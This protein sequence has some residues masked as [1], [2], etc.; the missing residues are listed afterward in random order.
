MITKSNGDR[1]QFDGSKVRRSILRSGG[2]NAEAD[3]VLRDVQ[4]ALPNGATTRVL[5]ATVHAS[6]CRT[7]RGAACRYTLRDALA[8]LGPAGFHFEKYIAALLA[9]SGYTT[10]LPDEIQGASVLHEIDV[11][12]RQG[13]KTFA[14]ECKFRNAIRD[15][16]H[17]KDTLAGYARYLDLLDG[18]DLGL[19]PKF[20]E[21]WIVTNTTFSD[22]ALTYGT[23]KGLKLL[24]WKHPDGK[25]LAA[26]IDR[27]RLY[28]I[29]V[30]RELTKH[31]LAAFSHAGLM[32]CQDFTRHESSEL[33][34]R[35]GLP[36]SRIEELIDLASEVLLEKE[37]VGV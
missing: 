10:E 20:Q 19:C 4:S 8:E 25:G 6:L 32:L 28:P 16:V 11:V 21:F 12:A 26:M 34:H 7:N 17:L 37:K 5:Y 13:H 23:D 36:Q 3:V 27:T 15:S 9:A 33:S 31:E 2:S 1:V 30:I 24:G 29:T 14:I 22:R 35:T 18:A